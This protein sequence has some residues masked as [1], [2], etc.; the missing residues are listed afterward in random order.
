MESTSVEA[1]ALVLSPT[2]ARTQGTAQV[3]IPP[4]LQRA[5]GA[6]AVFW[7][8]HPVTACD[9]V[10]GVMEALARE[11]IS[12]GLGGHQRGNLSRTARDSGRIP[13]GR[14]GRL[15]HA[16]A[17]ERFDLCGTLGTVMTSPRVATVF[18]PVARVRT[19]CSLVFG[20]ELFTDCSLSCDEVSRAR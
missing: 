3:Q 12:R 18:V 14:C 1:E 6:L 20:K 19:C 15:P 5:P 8:E 13:R 16:D 17:F 7:P 9:K 11:M 10:A 4:F 2:S